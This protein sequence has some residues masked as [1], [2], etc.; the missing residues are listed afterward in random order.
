MK[1]PASLA[2]I[3]LLAGILAACAPST[4]V[5][6]TPTLFAGAGL[7]KIEPG[8]RVGDFLITTGDPK[9]ELFIWQ[10]KTT[11]GTREN[12]ELVTVAWGQ[13]INPSIGVYADTD[14]TDL[15]ANWAS[16]AFELYINDQPVDLAA[17]G[18]V[19]SK[20][21]T[22]GTMRHWNVVILADKPGQVTVHSVGTYQDQ[23]IEY[24]TIYTVLPPGTPAAG[25]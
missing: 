3:A 4:P 13:A 18:T 9:N 2:L 20:E 10:Q 22:V 24:W 5:A 6:P 25:S 23:A 17:F 14:N 12:E 16:L 15:E 7:D 8:D 19:E 1:L 11:P 21:P